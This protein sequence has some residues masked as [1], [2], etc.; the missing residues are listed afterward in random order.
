MT[1]SDA[2]A[3]LGATPEASP[4]PASTPTVTTSPG[5]SPPDPAPTPPL[6]RRLGP[7]LLILCGAVLVS[8]TVGWILGQRYAPPDAA[9]RAETATL[10]QQVAN[11]QARITSLTSG[12]QSVTTEVAT[13]AARTQALAA[14]QGAGTDQ[15]ALTALAQR[16]AALEARP[17][18]GD[19][20]ALD[21][22]VAALNKK[23]A[24]VAAAS[25][26]ATARIARIAA[27]RAALDAGQPLGAIPDAPP[28][29]A[30]FATAAP[31]TEAQLRERFGPAA[32][33]ALEASRPPVPQG[34][35]ARLKQRAQFL[36]TIRVGGKVVAGP[37]AAAPIE[38][39]RQHLDAGDLAGAVA[40]LAPLDPAAA[41][42]M[43]PWTG[44]ARAL[45]A[46]RAALDALAAAPPTDTPA[47][48]S[49]A[50]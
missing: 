38:A 4:P 25:R 21:A 2:P 15:A 37:P 46:A 30:R 49:G 33:A 7:V 19:T 40:A 9:S 50:G 28:A 35:W 10:R 34:V 14:R 44:D 36:L 3:A 22:E 17:Q 31:P 1:D 20:A 45:L 47:S 48:G 23:L 11:D 29:L 26:S 27:A 24:S 8:V 41:R 32:A 12:M 13:L 42:A 16:V 39:A 5:A 6:G 43:A 18:G